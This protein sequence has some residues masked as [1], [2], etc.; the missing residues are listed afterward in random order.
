MRDG[1]VVVMEL[2]NGKRVI[3]IIS[4]ENAND[5][6]EGFDL[7]NPKLFITRK[8]KDGETDLY[9]YDSFL[10]GSAEDIV[11]IDIISVLY[12]YFADKDLAMDFFETVCIDTNDEDY[13]FSYTEDTDMEENDDH[14]VPKE[15]PPKKW[16]H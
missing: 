16:L 10:I 9:E 4:Q 13:G 1:V 15:E 7:Y 11:F 12:H 2:L 6:D 5:L 14:F 8:D 3:G